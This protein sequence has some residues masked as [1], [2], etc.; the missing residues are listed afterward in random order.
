[1][2]KV[3]LVWTGEYED[4]AVRAIFETQD[5]AMQFV[6]DHWKEYMYNIYIEEVPIGIQITDNDDRFKIVYAAD[7]WG[8]SAN[9][10][11]LREKI[12]A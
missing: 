7:I 1:M 8:Y 2:N 6:R 12:V 11:E 4:A 5:E 9:E 10:K 3:Y